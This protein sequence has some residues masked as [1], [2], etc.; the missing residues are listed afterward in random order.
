MSE[1]LLNTR[2]AAKF[3]RVSEASI[4]RWTDA[5]LLGVRRVGRRRERRFTEDDLR[6]FMTSGRET[7]ATAPATVFI[8]G[9][10][11]PLR[12]HV[13]TF[14]ATHDGRLRLSL[15]FIVEG[16]RA[17]QPCFLVAEGEALEQYR[18][19]IQNQLPDRPAVFDEKGLIL[20]SQTGNGEAF[21]RSWEASLSNALHSGPT[22]IRV[23][24]EMASVA[25]M[26]GSVPQ[27]L[28]FEAALGS[29]AKRFPV[30]YLCQYDVREFDGV[31]L[32]S[33][34]KDHPDI[35]ELPLGTFLI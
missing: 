18:Q 29:L 32:L 1:A 25:H 14:Y 20:I 7:V 6:Q 2:E 4:R 27:M 35:Y 12:S 22:V 30:V 10:A 19:A 24:G 34:L 5:G 9:T 21:T 16:L 26:M 23:V 31:A 13:S 17:G 3:L 8:R 33:V 11:V 28:I 15:P